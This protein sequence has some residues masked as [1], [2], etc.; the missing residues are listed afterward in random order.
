MAGS[1]NT[2][3][4]PTHNRRRTYRGL[5]ILDN[6]WELPLPDVLAYQATSILLLILVII[7]DYIARKIIIII[8]HKISST[9]KT[10]FDDLLVINKAPRN[11]AH[12]VPLIIALGL[13]PIVFSDFPDIEM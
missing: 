12:I 6:G 5:K 1:D 7:A 3:Q 13:T 11:I 9:S 2:D 4:C 8:S 10:K